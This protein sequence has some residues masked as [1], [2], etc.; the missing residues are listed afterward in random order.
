[1]HEAITLK[2]ISPGP[3]E[4]HHSKSQMTK[5]VFDSAAWGQCPSPP[6]LPQGQQLHL[7]ITQPQSQA[8]RESGKEGGKHCQGPDPTLALPSLLL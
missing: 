2:E 5:A 6:Y 7:T 1:M 3:H 4:C 8:T